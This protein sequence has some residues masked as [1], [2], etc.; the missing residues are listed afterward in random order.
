MAEPAPAA[1]LPGTP[2][3]D[4]F[5]ANL[6]LPFAC[7]AG[8]PWIT[9]GEE[10]DHRWVV[11]GIRMGAYNAVSR[12]RFALEGIDARIDEVLDRF[13]QASTPMS[14]WIVDTSQPADLAA[15]LEGRGLTLSGPLPVM[16]MGIVAWHAPAW[17]DG[18]DVT[19]ADSLDLVDEACHVVSEGYP[20]PWDAFSGVVERYG[21][22]LATGRE[23]RCYVARMG[24]RAV[25]SVVAMVDPDGAVVGLWNLAT[26]P[27][28]RRRGAATAIT[29][30]ALEDARADG[31]R[32][33]VLA[34]TPAAVSLY[35]RL[36][37]REAGELVIA[38][39][40][41]LAGS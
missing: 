37:F 6:W 39:R 11:T 35:R 19:R 9:L 8:R 23:L 18:I 13:V 36:G 31:C 15:R 22:L 20:V 25:A 32:R 2:I 41:A 30:A 24:R 10:P 1:D 21:D 14:W 27:D 38:G 4:A 34:S 28:A 17:P 40:G 29:I 33:A 7:A 26:L 16:G 3:L 5:E 12:T